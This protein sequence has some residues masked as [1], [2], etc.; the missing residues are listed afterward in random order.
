VSK[1]LSTAL[2]THLDSGTTTMALCWKIIRQ[3][4]LIQG[5]TEHDEDLV[6]AGQTYQARSGF[7]ASQVAQTLGLSVDNLNVEGAISSDTINED[8]LANGDY[9][10]AEVILTWANWADTTQYTILSRGYIGEVKRGET[11][12]SAE[13]RSLVTKLGQRT[14]RTYQRTCDAQLGDARCKINLNLAAYKGTGSVTSASGRNLIVS[15]LSSFAS[16]WFTHGLITFTSGACAGQTFEVK[17]HSGTS[18]LLWDIPPNTILSADAFTITAGCKQDFATCKAKFANQ[19][20]FQ[21]FPYVPGTD[22]LTEYPVTGQ[23]GM[24]GGSLFK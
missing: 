3:D 9:D 8:D 1:S 2:Q 15:G 23:G 5:F 24:D 11:A 7:S 13:F 21:G 12:F 10:S 14:G 4:G 16:D 22:R 18:V 19:L 17:K 6:V 20:N